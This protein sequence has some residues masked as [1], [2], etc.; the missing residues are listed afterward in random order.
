MEAKDEHIEKLIHELSP[1]VERELRNTWMR[2][3]KGTV[4]TGGCTLVCA[5][6]FGPVGFVVGE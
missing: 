1:D 2:L 4:V 6:L 3:L 5:A